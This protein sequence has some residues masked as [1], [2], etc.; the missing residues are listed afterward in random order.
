ML[1]A[2]SLSTRYVPI[3]VAMSV[4]FAAVASSA[5]YN[6]ARLQEGIT[7]WRNSVDSRGRTCVDC[8]GSPDGIDLA[9]WNLSAADIRRRDADHINPVDSEKI[10]GLMEELRKKYNIVP[11]DIRTVSPFQPG[12]T[13]LPGA[14]PNERDAAFAL[15]LESSLPTLAAG[16]VNSPAKGDTAVQ[17]IL[18]LD[19]HSQKLGIQLPHWSKDKHFGTTEGVLTDWISDVAM[20]PKSQAAMN[21]YYDAQDA[22]LT[23]PSED[24]LWA[25]YMSYTK[26]TRPLVDTMSSAGVTFM[27]NKYAA[28][29]IGAHDLRMETLGLPRILDK[30][31]RHSQ[32]PYKP[33]YGYRI[34]IDPIFDLGEAAQ[35]PSEYFNFPTTVTQTLNPAFTQTEHVRHGKDQW[36][37]MGWLYNPGSMTQ[38]TRHE[39]FPNSV[40]RGEQF[41]GQGN[42]RMPVHA[43]YLTAITD[44]Y[45]YRLPGP[46]G[47]VTKN[48]YW[49]VSGN[50]L[51]PFNPQPAF[52]GTASYDP[53]LEPHYFKD[54][55][56]R[57][58]AVRFSTN[59][60]KMRLYML[61]KDLQEALA[62][63]SSLDGIANGSPNFNPHG[64]LSN[65][66]RESWST[67]DFLEAQR[68][69]K[70]YDP[71]NATHNN[72]LIKEV[73]DLLRDYKNGSTSPMNGNGTGLL[74]RIYSGLRFSNLLQ[75][76]TDPTVHFYPGV[77]NANGSVYPANGISA[78]WTGYVQ[79]RYTDTYKFNVLFPGD[80]G[81]DGGVRIWVDGT[82]VYD[83]AEARVDYKQYSSDIALQAGVKYQF[84]VE[85]Q[86]PGTFQQV[87]VRWESSKELNDVIPTSQ[88]YPADL[89]LETQ[90]ATINAVADTYVRDGSYASS[91]YGSGNTLIVKSSTT[92]GY[93]RMSYLR[94]NLDSLSSSAAK[95]ELSLIVAG[96]PGT[97]DDYQSSIEVYKVANDSWTESGLTY[98]NRPSLGAKL[99]SV[100]VY[101]TGQ[102]IRFS[103]TDALNAELAGD[104][105]LSLA[106][107]QPSGGQ[108]FEIH[109]RE[110][111]ENGPIILVPGTEASTLAVTADSTTRNGSHA[112]KN[113]GADNELIAKH[114]FTSD[115]ERRG[116]L[117][118]NLAGFQP[119]STTKLILKI[120]GLGSEGANGFTMKVMKLSD[121]SWNETGVTW[122]NQPA[123]TGVP[124]A[125][126]EVFPS[127]IG[128]EIAIDVSAFVQAEKAGD[129]VAG[130]AL[131]QP[132]SA[133][134][135]IKI[136]SKESGSG[137][138]LQND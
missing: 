40:L 13:I 84:R 55:A 58:R 114:T 126:F 138:R 123:T 130:F 113:Y 23:N 121:D 97:T 9:Y 69:L 109:S 46:T 132:D 10:V 39:Y 37:W 136:S 19:L 75:E 90:A 41:Y 26:N 25:M 76:R 27:R 30:K 77:G 110:S 44:V 64:S 6:E 52:F 14:T 24:N 38:A 16:N 94:F 83:F 118:F 2:S 50:N 125:T 8:H 129:G 86:Q 104:R 48:Y 70:Q 106:L 3:E 43:K 127:D 47:P 63:D 36:W 11:K 80:E 99:G 102:E 92:A 17:E 62:T 12:G 61:R 54:S 100:K 1:E 7:V 116:L 57:Q 42:G 98:A 115:Y 15:Q 73:R 22:Y 93:L 68:Q 119:S 72:A 5:P 88:L 79:P 111:G 124:L 67:H 131:V 74:T 120:N 18:N 137:A 28:S 59:V 107:V 51:S 71:T 65:V 31:S 108:M 134:R 35:N 87:S 32:T 34:M 133:N 20:V 29:M 21:E 101:R 103:I 78:R 122:A 89:Q 82:L 91:N 60:T 66:S 117:K 85:Y 53:D 105:K 128:K 49:S 4:T 95:A 45:N 33:E 81:Q 56:H 112:G 135:M 96:V